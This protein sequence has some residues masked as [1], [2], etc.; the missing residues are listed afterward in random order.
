MRSYQKHTSFQAG[1]G[2]GASEEGLGYKF[3]KGKFNLPLTSIDKSHKAEMHENCRVAIRPTASHLTTTQ[4][5]ES[6]FGC[7]RQSRSV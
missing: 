5:G 1:W 4:V 6:H 7:G 3:H 2:G